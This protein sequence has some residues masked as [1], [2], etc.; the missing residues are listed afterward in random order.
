M[1]K[2]DFYFD[3]QKV[4]EEITNWRDLEIEVNFEDE[5]GIGSIKS[6]NLEFALSIA[7]KINTWNSNG[8][9]GG[10]GIFE[11]PPFRIE[12]C[13][14][15]DIVFNGGINIADCTTLYE[16][17]KIIAPLR[18]DKIDFLNDKAS[19]FTFAYLASIAASAPG[20]IGQG[21]YLSVPY[22]INSIPD[23]VNIMVAGL[24][25]FMLIK[26]LQEVIE[27]TIAVANELSGDVAM[28]LGSVVNPIIATAMAIGRVLVDIV[29]I[30]LYILY[31][32]FIIKAIIDLVIMI[33]DNLI[34]PV[35]YKKGMLVRTLF[36][37]AADYMGFTF[38]STLLNSAAHTNDVIIPRKIAR[39]NTP[40]L[41][42]SLFGLQNIT[43][44][45]NDDNHN[46]SSTGFFEGTFADL[47]I[48]EE[49]RLNA[50]LR[51]IGGAI[52]FETKEFFANFANYT[53]PNIQRKNADP[54]GTN[55]CELAANYILSYSLDS[56]DT[57]TYDQYDGTSCQMQLV[58]AVILNKKNVLLKNLIEITL[59]Y[60]LAKRKTSLNGVEEVVSVLYNIAGT[61]YNAITG[62]FNAILGVINGILT[63]I[64]A[65]TGGSAPQIPLIAPFPPNPIA[66]RIGMMLLSS[67]FIGIQ[68]ILSIDP[69]T[70]K[71]H[72]NNQTLTAAQ[73]LID[74]LHFTNFA[75]RTITTTGAPK[76]DHNQWLTYTDK[77]IPFCCGDYQSVLNN[78]YIKTYDQ[79]I[80][81]IKSLVWNPIKETARI[82][83][84]VKEQYTKNLIQ[85]Y[86]IDGKP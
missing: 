20:H 5:S 79:K 63:A 35:K 59:Q 42:Q 29:R 76:N 21:D 56:Q 19:A 23:F 64:S 67:D 1:A 27:K 22:V 3:T 30:V 81:K 37:K 86:V 24:S 72:S 4:N 7:D 11:A 6:G 80:A 26:E 78:N 33:F 25:L 16:C 28:A 49:Q 65:L 45:D 8:M 14:S 38:S 60:A 69:S 36:Q 62:F 17:D 40:T 13:G 70:N 46:P 57:N 61:I 82:T 48:I 32:V 31:L 71:L 9:A 74:E 77:E 55:A 84:R 85:T 53:L 51:V 52:Y 10:A 66:A 44:K 43:H 50:E 54:H 34:Q 12:V 73:T 41:V 18:S 39:L 83:Y 15:G 68:K 47:V 58:P 75:V 2:L